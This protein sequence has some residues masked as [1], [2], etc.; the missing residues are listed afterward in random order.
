MS[1]III[2]V[3]PPAV[4]PSSDTLANDYLGYAEKRVAADTLA[5]QKTQAFT[6]TLAPIDLSA[7]D[8][9]GFSTAFP[10]PDDLVELEGIFNGSTQLV[11]LSEDDLMGV[12]SGGSAWVGDQSFCVVGRFLYI[13]PAPSGPLTLLYRHLPADYAGADLTLTGQEGR[14]VTRLR[15]AYVY[16]D[17]GQPEVGINEYNRYV[18]DSLGSRRKNR[19]RG[20][21]VSRIPVKETDPWL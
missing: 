5:L 15:D 2:P 17:A 19:T 8:D 21:T 9:L 14:L 6:P 3:N 4:E 16:L 7:G 11:A 10:L 18:Q 1:P 13:V 20:G 12:L